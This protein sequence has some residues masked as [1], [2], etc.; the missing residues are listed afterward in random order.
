MRN[1]PSYKGHNVKLLLGDGGLDLLDLTA[2]VST[3]LGAHSV[4]HMQSTALGA[5]HQSGS[6]QLPDGAAALIAS[7]LR[8]FSL[9][10]CHGYTSLV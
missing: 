2:I 1:L 8:N 9:R 10:D 4:R 7:L 6:G 3:A 5:S